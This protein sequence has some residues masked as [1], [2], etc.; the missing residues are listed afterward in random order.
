MLGTLRGSSGSE[1]HTHRR[2]FSGVIRSTA[3]PAN[4]VRYR[5]MRARATWSRRSGHTCPTKGTAKERSKQPLRT[6]ARQPHRTTRCRFTAFFSNSRG[7]SRLLEKIQCNVQIPDKVRT[8]HDDQFQLLS[9]QRVCELCQMLWRPPSK[10]EM[11]ER[12]FDGLL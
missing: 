7:T 12:M 1:R 8:R 3:Y 10:K 2:R 9:A 11:D 5:T 6:K 4:R